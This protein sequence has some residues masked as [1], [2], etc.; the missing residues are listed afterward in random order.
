MTKENCQLLTLS[1]KIILN[2]ILN[3]YYE[4]FQILLKNMVKRW[5]FFVD[6]MN[7]IETII[8]EGKNLFNNELANIV[9]YRLKI[10]FDMTNFNK[11]YFG[12]GILNRLEQLKKKNNDDNRVD[13]NLEAINDVFSAK[14]IIDEVLVK[15][16]VS[17]KAKHHIKPTKIEI[18]DIEE[19]IADDKG[20]I[21]ISKKKSEKLLVKNIMYKQIIL[22]GNKV[23][24]TIIKEILSLLNSLNSKLSNF[25]D[26]K[27]KRVSFHQN[28][29]IAETISL[30]SINNPE[31]RKSVY[32]KL[33]SFQKF[34]SKKNLKLEN[35]ESKL[36]FRKLKTLNFDIKNET[37]ENIMK[38]VYNLV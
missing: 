36:F 7:T 25:I 5:N 4:F 16:K 24:H 34:E 30:L 23:F 21:L 14:E 19:D 37:N 11:Y 26:N 1:K 9:K 31:P 33:N 35:T 10:G 3:N 29:R 8:N 6:I 28:S 2:D 13:Y 12:I 17:R 18:S 32:K 22:K 38:N 20:K 27:N 15:R